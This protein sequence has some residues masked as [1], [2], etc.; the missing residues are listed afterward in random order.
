MLQQMSFSTK[1]PIWQKEGEI[2]LPTP[3]A[4]KEN[5]NNGDIAWVQIY[6]YQEA[7][8]LPQQKIKL[9]YLEIS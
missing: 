1:A 7:I 6:M 3:F 8:M 2:F 4:F 5:K 9:S